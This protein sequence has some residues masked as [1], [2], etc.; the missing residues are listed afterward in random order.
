MNYDWW[1]YTEVRGNVLTWWPALLC[2]VQ[3][4]TLV[5]IQ[6]CLWG[7]SRQMTTLC[8]AMSPRNNHFH[9]NGTLFHRIRLKS[10]IF[11]ASGT[12]EALFFFFFLQVARAGSHQFYCAANIPPSDIKWGAP[13]ALLALSGMA[14]IEDRKAALGLLWLERSAGRLQ[15][16]VVYCLI[17]LAQCSRF[18]HATPPL[19]GTVSHKVSVN[20][21][22]ELSRTFFLYTQ[23]KGVIKAW[24]DPRARRL[25][26]VSTSHSCL[27]WREPEARQ[28]GF[29]LS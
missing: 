27:H 25:K 8:P 7:I 18:G 24:G 20:N 13:A 29:M 5:L 11:L 9:G 15:S 12:A 2:I 1:L 16:F 26:A 17:C 21:S 28:P 14:A 3:L 22:C 23:L 6:V 4:N 10:V 19:T